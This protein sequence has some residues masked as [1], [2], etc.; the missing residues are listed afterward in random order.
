MCSALDV[1]PYDEPAY[2]RRSCEAVTGH[3][4]DDFG[5][6]AIR[7]SQVVAVMRWEDTGGVQHFAC[8]LH[9]NR[10]QTLWPMAYR[11]FEGMESV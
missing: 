9:I 5:F 10:M 8:P 7:C 6:V 3:A 4:Y 11:M 2:P 1:P